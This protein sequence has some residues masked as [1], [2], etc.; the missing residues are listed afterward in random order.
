MNDVKVRVFGEAW[1]FV[2]GAYFVWL[3]GLLL[4]EIRQCWAGFFRG[5]ELVADYC[6]DLFGFYNC[7][8]F[9]YVNKSA[10]TVIRNHKMVK[11]Y[12]AMRFGTVSRMALLPHSPLLF[13][14]LRD[15]ILKSW[16]PATWVVVEAV[17]SILEVASLFPFMEADWS[18]AV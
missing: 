4:V 3:K 16:L 2:T 6:H 15:A 11:L 1:I 13:P 12:L 18:G 14:S 17:A 8:R 9:A 5:F 10:L 7:L